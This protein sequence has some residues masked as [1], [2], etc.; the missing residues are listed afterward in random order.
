MDT[1]L[2]GVARHWGEVCCG[3]VNRAKAMFK[4]SDDPEKDANSSESL[5]LNGIPLSPS[6]S[7]DFREVV[8]NT[9]KHNVFSKPLVEADSYSAVYMPSI[10]FIDKPKAKRRN[11]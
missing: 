6:S 4:P 8:G 7:T 3:S 1:P 10:S 2:S 9:R 11:S 5:V